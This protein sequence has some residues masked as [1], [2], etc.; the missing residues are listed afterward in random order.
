MSRV[1][2]SCLKSLPQGCA[3]CVLAD[4]CAE[5]QLYEKGRAGGIDEL[6]KALC[7]YNLGIKMYTLEE[8]EGIWADIRE[9]AE[10]VK[11]QKDVRV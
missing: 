3:N 4:E 1:F 7:E 9:I 8:L 10:K 5:K 11:E 2:E 6:T